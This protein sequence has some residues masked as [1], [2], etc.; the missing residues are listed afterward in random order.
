MI[1]LSNG[2]RQGH[3]NFFQSLRN[4]RKAKESGGIVSVSKGVL[5]WAVLTAG[6]L[7]LLF[8]FDLLG[9]VLEDVLSV[10]LEFTQENI[11]SLYRKQFKLDVYHAQ[12]ATAYTGLVVIL[13]AGYFL[14]K[15]VLAAIKAARE[16]WDSWREKLLDACLSYWDKVME[17]WDSM[18][19]VNKCFALIGLVVV[20]IPLVS[21]ACIALGRAVAELI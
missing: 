12:M 7:G 9:N 19:N 21:I 5:L 17:W 10:L 1:K 18:D 3:S 11:E 6:L 20:A 4:A 13:A 14:V 16:G 2:M 15:K 8:G